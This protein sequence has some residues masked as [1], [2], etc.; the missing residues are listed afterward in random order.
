MKARL[1][2]NMNLDEII[3]EDMMKGRDSK[4]RLFCPTFVMKELLDANFWAERLED[5][6]VEKT[7][8]KSL[9]NAVRKY[10]LQDITLNS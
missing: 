1:K 6:S 4:L 5:G 2:G 7:F 8:L 10:D 3:N 9:P